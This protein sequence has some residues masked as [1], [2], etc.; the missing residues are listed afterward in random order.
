MPN[1]TIADDLDFWW[2]DGED[3]VEGEQ[4]TAEASWPLAEGGVPAP[5]PSIFEPPGVSPE[6]EPPEHVEA[7]ERVLLTIMYRHQDRLGASSLQ[8][9]EADL[10]AG[11]DWASRMYRSE[12]G[13]FERF[14]RLRAEVA[15]KEFF[16]RHKA[17]DL[18]FERVDQDRREAAIRE[19]QAGIARYLQTQE[20]VV[21]RLQRSRSPRW[22][23]P[24]RSAED[25]RGEIMVETL[26][27][28]RKPDGFRR[29]LRVARAASYQLATWVVD[30][31]RAKRL[32][33]VVVKPADVDLP[34]SGPT[35]EQCLLAA[36]RERRLGNMEWKASGHLSR[37]QSR[38]MDGMKDEC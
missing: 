13:P 18:R 5:R 16:A 26:A 33:S 14:A 17:R 27:A 36:E 6:R 32:I 29:H 30:R 12:I 23:V 24:E 2:P 8:A 35:P 21:K 11:L 10:S 9:L 22:K 15:E 25:V 1:R 3:L 4:P 20:Q 7:A 38:W 34:S 19:G 31:L 28:L 37:I